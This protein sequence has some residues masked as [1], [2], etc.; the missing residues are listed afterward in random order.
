[1]TKVTLVRPPSIVSVGSYIGSLTPPIGLTYIAAALRNK[2][3]EVTI[4]DSVGLDP[5]KSTYLGNKLILRG[6]SENT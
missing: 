5:E 6:I 1:M 3:H 2:N 4:V